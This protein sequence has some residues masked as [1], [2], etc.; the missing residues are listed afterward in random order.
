VVIRVTDPDT[1]WDSLAEVC[2]VPAPLLPVSCVTC[3]IDYF[4]ESLRE[5]TRIQHIS[6]SSSQQRQL[7]VQHGLRRVYRQ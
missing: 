5:N 2:T 6:H 1:D 4:E 3:G 7:G